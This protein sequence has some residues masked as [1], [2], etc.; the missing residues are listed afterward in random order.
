MTAASRGCSAGFKSS[1]P[2]RLLRVT[3]HAAHASFDQTP[4]KVHQMRSGLWAALFAAAVLS[5]SGVE[6]QGIDAQCPAGST[7]SAG[8]PDNTKI[9]QDACQKAIDLFKYMAPQLGAVLAGGNPTQGLAG[10]LGGLGHFS[11]GI[12]AN[13]L[14]GSL[15]EVDKIVPSRFGA[16]DT[17]YSLDTK[18]IGFVTAD[19]A[20]GIFKGLAP[21]GFGAI[22]GILTASYIPEY[23][24]E[25]VEVTVPSGGLKLGYGAKLGI[26]SETAV[27][28]GVS[29]SYVSRELPVVTIV[30]KSGDDRLDLAGVHVRAKS[31]KGVVGKKL[32][33]LGLAAGY[34]RDTYDSNSTIAVTVAPRGATAGGTGGPILLSQNISRNNIFAS[35]WID[36]RILRIVGEIGRVSGGAITT[37]NSFE[38]VQPAD[39]RNYASIGLSIGR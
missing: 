28:P 38:G 7:N 2:G 22:D 27:R 17:T 14:N 37:Y 39:A 12:R 36:G 6:A 34:G 19:L 32:A 5:A 13:A 26:L 33:F 31:W 16:E 4:I 9:A 10:T 18:P 11:A 20:V 1:G 8:E 23:N 29:V 30:G 24:G 15:P 21:T 25:S 35:A 3:T